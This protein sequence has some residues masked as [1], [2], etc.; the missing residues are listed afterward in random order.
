MTPAVPRQGVTTHP[1]FFSA[2]TRCI[3]EA[4]KATIFYGDSPANTTMQ[5]VAKRAKIQEE[6]ISAGVLEADFSHGNIMRYPQGKVCN[7]FHIAQGVLLA[8]AIVSIPKLK[9]HSLTTI[10]GAVKNQFGCVYKN[11]SLM[12]GR[13]PRKD[14]FIHM[15][16]DL[17]LMLKPKLKLFVM[18]AIVS[19]QGEGPYAGDIAKTNFIL[20][21]SDAVALDYTACLLIKANTHRIPLLN[22]AEKRGLGEFSDHLELLCEKSISSL[23]FDAFRLPKTTIIDRMANLLRCADRFRRAP[24][25]DAECCNGCEKCIQICPSDK[26]AI[27]KNPET[28]KCEIRAKNCIRCY[29][30]HEICPNK[31]INI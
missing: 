1:V 15:L 20:L 2:V 14:K 8:D 22:I 10:S 29:C 30:C 21:S 24:Y 7:E 25:I 23:R 6:A 5:I 27:I 4:S 26:G 18:D 9:T 16:I 28:R 13:Y 12:H 11:K 31:A 17:N 3:R 19:M